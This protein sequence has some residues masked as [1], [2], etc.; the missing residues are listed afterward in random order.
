MAKAIWG[1]DFGN[2][3]LKVVRASYDKKSDTLTLNLY[4]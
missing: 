3:S 2:W 4:D 1:I